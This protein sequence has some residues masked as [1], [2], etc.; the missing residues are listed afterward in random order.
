MTDT[1]ARLEVLF[2]RLARLRDDELMALSAREERP[3]AERR[4]AR[5]AAKSVL[6]DARRADLQIAEE[7]LRAWAMSADTSLPA[8]VVGT[9]GNVGQ[10]EARERALPIVADAVLAVLTADQLD[11]QDREVLT[12]S[13]LAEE[14]GIA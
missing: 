5:D 11:P 14:M 8:G 13:V 6:A 9:F 12:D 10:L 7:M 2:D 3:P 1:D 4:R